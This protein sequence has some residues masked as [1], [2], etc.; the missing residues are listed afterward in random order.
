MVTL[1]LD[2][3]QLEVVLS[4]TERAVA[5]RRRNITI[6]RSTIAKVQ[7][8]DD[9]WTWLRGVPDP[10]T[11]LP[12]A[13]AAGSWKSAGGRDFVLLR[14]RKPSVVIDLEGHPEFQRI[15][16]TTRHGISLV[17]ALRLATG[18]LGDEP[19]DVAE[20]VAE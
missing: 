13:L 20:L 1:L 18:D 8:T 16:L 4:R 19:A 5:F 7:L 2:S 12:V 11:Y 6:E 15:M 10:G 17:Q 9:A 14:G 3:A